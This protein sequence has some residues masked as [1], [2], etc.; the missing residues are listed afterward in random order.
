MAGALAQFFQ[1]RRYFAKHPG[2]VLPVGMPGSPRVG[3]TPRVNA[4][5]GIVGGF[6]EKGGSG[7]VPEMEN[8]GRAK[9]GVAPLKF[10]KI[11]ETLLLAM[12]CK[13]RPRCEGRTSPLPAFST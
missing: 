2:L 10:G 13:G 5:G 6:G 11:R 1:K 3:C 8:G 12:R 4:F 9:M 7:W